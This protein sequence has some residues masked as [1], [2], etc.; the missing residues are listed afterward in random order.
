MSDDIVTR[1]REQ[2]SAEKP[3]FPKNYLT[4][5][6]DEIERLREINNERASV[7]RQYGQIFLKQT[8]EIERWRKIADDL[9]YLYRHTVGLEG[10]YAPALMAYE[11]AKNG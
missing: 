11:R 1:L 10:A 4:E 3:C 6:A 7:N 8:D 5:A 9:A 2:V